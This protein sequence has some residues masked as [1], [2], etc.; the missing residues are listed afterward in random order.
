ME[1][2]YSLLDICMDRLLVHTCIVL[3]LYCT[4]SSSLYVMYCC[5]NRALYQ[6]EAILKDDLPYQLVCENIDCKSVCPMSV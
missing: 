2:Y 1:S 4:S 3:S 6:V 5:P